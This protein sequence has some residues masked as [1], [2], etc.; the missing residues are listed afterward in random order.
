MT[1]HIVALS[2]SMR[3]PSRTAGAAA[4]ALAG[5]AAAGATTEL[6]SVRD[7]ALPMFDDREDS[8]SYPPEVGRL[9]ETIR[10]ADGLILASPVYHGTL[11]GAMKNALDF[12]H[13]AGRNAVAGKVAGLVSMAGGGTGINT[14]N[15]LDYVARALRLWTVPT[16]VAIPGAAYGPDGTLRD[17]VIA[18]RLRALG[19]QVARHAALLAQDDQAARG[20]A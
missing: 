7:L 11:T 18:E 10:R 1:P 5:A 3:S 14:L 17:E 8:A 4:I 13:L 9:L 19:R 20:V 15:T 12:L 16:T 6:L 2:G